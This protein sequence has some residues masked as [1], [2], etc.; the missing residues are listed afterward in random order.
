METMFADKKEELKSICERYGVSMLDL[1][2]SAVGED[3][4]P[5]GSDLDF[6]VSFESRTPSSLFDRYFGL[7]KEL[8]ELF[9]RDVD[10][11]MEG[12]IR[13]PYFAESVSESRTTLYAA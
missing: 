10:L 6:L 4:D 9:G 7:K 5:E 13:N 8:E 3:F 1:F 11:V 2:G 12:A